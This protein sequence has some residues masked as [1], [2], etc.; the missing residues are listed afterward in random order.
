MT[1]ISINQTSSATRDGHLKIKN[2]L[3][4]SSSLQIVADEFNT[5]TAIQLSTLVLKAQSSEQCPL[6]VESTGTGGGISLM[7]NTTTDADSVG[8][9]AFGD[10]LC[11]RSGGSAAGN[12][13]LTAAGD[14]GIGTNSPTTRL[15]VNGDTD[16]LVAKFI[17]TD[18]LSYISFLDALTTS[19]TS[20]AL[21]ASSDNLVFYTGTSFG[22]ER[23][24]IDSSGNVGIGVSTPTARLEISS[25][26][27]GDVYLEGGTA[28]TRQLSFSTFANISDHAGHL[29]NASST[30]GAIAFA[31]GGS[32]AMRINSN[33]DVGIGTSSP[34]RKLHV[35]EAVNGD[36]ALF[37][38]T[39]DADLNIN[40]SS[41]V[42]L[43]SPST[44][45]LAFGTSSTER[46]RIDSSGNLGIGTS[47]PGAP[48][49]VN[50]VVRVASYIEGSFFPYSLTVGSGA[51]A[52]ITTLRGGSTASQACSVVVSGGGAATNPNSV[53]FN[54]A[55]NEIGRWTTNG[56]T[57]NGDTAAANAL[58]DYEEGTFTPTL[59]FG[60]GTTAIAYVV[61]LGKYT[62]VGNKVTCEV[63]IT[64]SNKGTDT[65][66]VSITGF[67]FTH[68]AAY[69]A[70]VSF[71]NVV[72]ISFADFLQGF[73]EGGQTAV[74]LREVTNAGVTTALNDTNFANNTTLYFSITYLSA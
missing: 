56:L 31:T 27:Q 9:G 66:D 57:F 30:N 1:K 6:E 74:F 51:D 12:M 39:I 16:N 19:E 2:G 53:V 37:T 4:I 8:I 45:T 65:G 24:R 60:G 46:M 47:S 21:G 23:M 33:Q 32:E 35:S 59:E 48:L 43:L 70:G 36:I 41:G 3:P 11:F 72:S 54:V 55:S 20:V 64:L 18:F 73:I 61:Q 68:V 52:T 67:P 15:E 50:G 63:A 29:I 7:D 44:T 17:S 34:S 42:T 58:D 40:L 26:N 5:D 28:D 69:R 25:P 62:K 22:S 10:D 49:D 13:R 14:L 38:N 71:A